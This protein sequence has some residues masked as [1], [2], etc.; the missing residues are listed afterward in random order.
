M[1]R[2]SLLILV[3]LT[4]IISGCSKDDVSAVILQ[5]KE[6]KITSANGSGITGTATFTE[7]SNGQTSI[8]IELDNT[9]TETHPA[10]IRYNSANEGGPVAITLKACTCSVGTT[11]V[12][13]LDDGT[14]IDYDGLL[15]LD[16][17]ISISDGPESIK[18]IVATANIGSN[19]N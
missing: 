10:Y 15:K 17:H 19:G 5:S 6:Y 2:S 1:K 4:V 11:I 14:P 18:L 13:K 8:L 16:G 9:D 7:D 12:T 3:C